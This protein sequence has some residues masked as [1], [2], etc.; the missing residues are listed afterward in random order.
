MTTYENQPNE[1]DFLLD[2]IF[3][4]HLDDIRILHQALDIT[5]THFPSGDSTKWN[6][7]PIDFK[8]HFHSSKF[9]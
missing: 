6:N 9:N 3:A 1:D 5:H 2:H 7:L 4:K 8:N